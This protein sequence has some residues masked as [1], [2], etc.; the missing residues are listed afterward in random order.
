MAVGAGR[1]DE[2]AHDELG[3]GIAG[4][5]LEVGAEGIGAGAGA[6]PSPAPA[7]SPA[8][9]GGGAAPA[10]VQTQAS[11]DGSGLAVAKGCISCHA[12][13]RV[14]LGPAF[15]DIAA[16]YEYSADNIVAL[17]ENVRNGSQGKWAARLGDSLECPAK[18]NLVSEEEA[19]K[20]VVWILKM[21][22]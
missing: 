12:A 15:K 20:L 22:K 16:A 11:L 5:S 13:D 4:G 19:K 21:K 17:M 10:P 3:R 18:S 7:P 8:A 9:G 2:G 1:L 6:S 14:V